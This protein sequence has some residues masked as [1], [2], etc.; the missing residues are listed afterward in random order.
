MNYGCDLDMT[1]ITNCQKRMQEFEN[2]SMSNA[3]YDV[4]GARWAK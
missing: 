4:L 2:R 3:P 1:A